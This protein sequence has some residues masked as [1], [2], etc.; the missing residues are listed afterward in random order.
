MASSEYF[1]STYATLTLL[2]PGHH[3]GKHKELQELLKYSILRGCHVLCSAA[4]SAAEAV[5]SREAYPGLAAFLLAF[6][7]QETHPYDKIACTMAVPYCIR[8]Y[9][10]RLVL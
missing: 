10:A 6:Q 2:V 3:D 5:Q 4:V 9:H 7:R 8:P 1:P